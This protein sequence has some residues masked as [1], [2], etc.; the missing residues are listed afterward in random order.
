MVSIPEEELKISY[1]QSSGPGGQNVNKIASAAQLRFDIKN[2]PSLSE[3]VKHR[4]TRLAGRRV[5][6]D[7]VLVIEARRYRERERNRQDAIERL[8]RL[9]EQARQTP[10]KRVPTRPHAGAERER[11]DDKKRRSALK[12]IRKFK[13]ELDD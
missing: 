11:L 1:V 12:R 7:S 13:P 2:S 3:P 6:E 5:T 8:F 4:L 10:V 9:V